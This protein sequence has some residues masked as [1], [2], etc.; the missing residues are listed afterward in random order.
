[1]IHLPP[2]PLELSKPPNLPFF[3]LGSFLSWNPH[4]QEVQVGLTNEP[5]NP[6]LCW[7]ERKNSLLACQRHS[8]D[9]HWCNL[10]RQLDGFEGVYVPIDTNNPK[11]NAFTWPLCTQLSCPTNPIKIPFVDPTYPEHIISHSM[12]TSMRR[13]EWRSEA[14]DRTLYIEQHISLAIVY[15]PHIHHSL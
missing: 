15:V 2:S 3:N 9:F 6:A 4:L 14:V 1:M 11:A 5:V 10:W 13:R 7:I 12:D 8:R